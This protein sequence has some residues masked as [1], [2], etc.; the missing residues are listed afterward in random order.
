[1][2][3]RAMLPAFRHTDPVSE[4]IGKTAAKSSPP[5]KAR[6]A[7]KVRAALFVLGA[8]LAAC[9]KPAPFFPV[10]LYGVDDPKA[11][12]SLREAGFNAIQSYSRDAALL[13]G[14]ARAARSAG[15]RA[16]FHPD[17]LMSSGAA[18]RGVP[19]AA[20]YLVDEPDVQRMAPE[21]LARREAE[22][23]AWSGGATTAFVLGDGRAA[24]RYAGSGDVLM[25]DWYPVPHLPLTS[26]GEQVRRTVEAAK[27]RPVWAVIQAFDWRDYPQ[28]DPRKPRIG[29]FPDLVELRFMSYLALIEGAR[30][31]WFFSYR[32]PSGLTLAD[33]PE[34]W[35]PVTSVAREVSLLAPALAEGRRLGTPPAL[36]AGLKG[37]ML[38]H[39]GRT[40]YLLANASAARVPLPAYYRDAR[41]RP[42]FEVR[43]SV[44]ENL[45]VDKDGAW[46]A[47]W[48]VLVL[49]SREVPLT[50]PS[51]TLS[52]SVTGR[53]K[54]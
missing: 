18:A 40:Y 46:L 44:E 54:G 27:G 30:G 51:G 21:A 20:W 5:R 11:L 53:G 41:F 32:R 2:R 29:R 28:H 36:G 35:W 15:L 38:S 16:L 17:A 25:V 10:G 1:M 13:S 7:S 31:L 48:R 49:E 45:D 3:R 19:L 26:V 24:E 23:K 47:P 33:S 39:A 8:G 34:L 9:A 52:P 37:L 4:R 6:E 42:L 12:A 43:R 22:V 14:L 50:R